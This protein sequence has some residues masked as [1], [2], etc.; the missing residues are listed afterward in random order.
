MKYFVAQSIMDMYRDVLEQIPLL[1]DVCSPLIIA[2][3][4]QVSSAG[5]CM[6]VHVYII[7]ELQLS[8]DMA[9]CT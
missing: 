8:A 1:I 3:Q 2:D 4:T 9:I 5:L 7:L 6:F